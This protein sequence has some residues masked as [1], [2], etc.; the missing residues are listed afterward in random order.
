ML[1]ALLAGRM[2]R[3]LPADTQARFPM[4]F[5]WSRVSNYRVDSLRIYL[6]RLLHVDLS[7]VVNPADNSPL[8][9]VL[10]YIVTDQNMLDS[11]GCFLG[12]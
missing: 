12:G 9:L 4:T 8:T 3:C 6:A 1:I 11:N 10:L 5:E 7:S 2:M